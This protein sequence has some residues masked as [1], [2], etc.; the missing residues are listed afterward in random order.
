MALVNHEEL[1]Y[2]IFNNVNEWLK[3]AEAKNFGLLTLNAAII[4]G[5]SQTNF[6]D[7]STI[8]K[9][10]FYGF[11]PFALFSFLIALISLFP[12][13][14]TIEKGDYVKSWIDNF[15]N[16]IEK[17]KKFENIHFYGYLK[18]IDETEFEAKFI[19][20]NGLP[21]TTSFSQYDR[22]LVTQIL[23]NS[24]ITSLKYQFFKISANLFL[25]G[26]VSFLIALLLF[27]YL[28]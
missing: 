20:K 15:S 13:L 10:V 23:Y 26:I 5:A 2:K 17:E 3:F 11:G 28:N 14:S 7:G 6:A 22:E 12:I 24:R 25:F 18:G 21:A 27:E 1:L 16:W 9:S 19:M 8:A 4:F